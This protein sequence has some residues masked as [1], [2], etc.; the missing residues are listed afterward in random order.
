MAPIAHIFQ[1]SSYEGEP[2]CWPDIITVT[3]HNKNIYTNNSFHSLFIFFESF[4]V[5]FFLKKLSFFPA[6]FTLIN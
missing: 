1:P 5:L 4:H 6:Q 3:T 2:E